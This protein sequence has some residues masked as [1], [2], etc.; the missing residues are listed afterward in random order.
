MSLDLLWR[1]GLL[2]LHRLSP[3][4]QRRARLHPRAY[5]T[6]PE[7]FGRIGCL[8]IENAPPVSLPKSLKITPISPIETVFPSLGRRIILAQI[9]LRRVRFHDAFSAVMR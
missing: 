8:T 1:F 9:F 5:V 2:S 6:G 7:S 4:L 3:G